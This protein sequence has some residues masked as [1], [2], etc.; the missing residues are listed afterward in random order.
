MDPTKNAG[1]NQFILYTNHA[2]DKLK[3]NLPF[4]PADGYSTDTILL[5]RYEDIDE[6]KSL[7]AYGPQYYL[8][9][10]TPLAV[11]NGNQ[12]VLIPLTSIIAAED[13]EVFKVLKYSPIGAKWSG[14]ML[15]MI[16]F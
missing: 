2:L 16:L 15:I 9:G 11:A 3:Y 5:N 4:S 14:L 12:L 8:D 7:I 13:H 10:V 6:R 1:N